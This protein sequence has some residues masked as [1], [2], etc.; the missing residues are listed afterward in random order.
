MF[1]LIYRLC[2]GDVGAAHAKHSSAWTYILIKA[3]RRVGVVCGVDICQYKFTPNADDKTYL[4]EFIRLNTHFNSRRTHTQARTIR[5]GG[6]SANP[7][8]ICALAFRMHTVCTHDACELRRLFFPH[9]NLNKRT[10]LKSQHMVIYATL[11]M[12][13]ARSGVGSVCA[14]PCIVIQ[15]FGSQIQYY[16]NICGKNDFHVISL[17]AFASLNEMSAKRRKRVMSPARMAGNCSV[18]NYLLVHE[19]LTSFEYW[20]NNCNLL[21]LI[22]LKSRAYLFM[23]SRSFCFALY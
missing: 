18:S 19:C 10:F 8:F 20:E 9:Y 1:A 17:C 14:T 2:R 23:G 15:Q 4:Y 13:M 5:S 16:W 3:L 21:L 22:L 7:S 6:S 11:L 12:T